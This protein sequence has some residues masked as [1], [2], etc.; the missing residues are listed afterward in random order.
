MVR[1]RGCFVSAYASP[2]TTSTYCRPAGISFSDEMY[3]TFVI[4]RP[5][6]LSAYPRSDGLFVLEK[7]C[8][9]RSYESTVDLKL[10]HPKGRWGLR[11]CWRTIATAAG[12]AAAL[13]ILSRSR[14]RTV[15]C[16]RFLDAEFLEALVFG[17]GEH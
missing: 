5:L 16:S 8:G 3:F 13:M 11:F 4:G 7:K 12:R 9:G 15:R 14:D 10:F 17:F 6:H 1:P 2:Y